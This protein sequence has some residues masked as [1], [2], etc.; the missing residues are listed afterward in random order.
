MYLLKCNFTKVLYLFILLSCKSFAQEGNYVGINFGLSDFHLKDDH[1]SPLI[2]RG[3]GITPSIQFMYKGEAAIHS[4]ELSYYY[5]YLGSINTNFN[6]NNWRGKV[7]YSYLHFIIDFI[8]PNNQLALF[9]GAS[10]SSFLSLSDYRYIDDNLAIESWYWNHSINVELELIYSFNPKEYITAQCGVPAISNI[11]RPEYSPSNNYSYSSNRYIV[12]TFDKMMYFPDNF[13]I[14]TILTY[15]TPIS[16]MFSLQI[17]YEFFY[18]LYNKPKEV[19]M[20]MN[21]ARAG[22]FWQF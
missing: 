22:L 6:T 7:K 14:N 1:A 2:F 13:F 11:S 16:R 5:D 21:N 10:L 12:T 4:V 17:E 19:S 3:I 9:I 20:Y 18:S 15:H 8:E